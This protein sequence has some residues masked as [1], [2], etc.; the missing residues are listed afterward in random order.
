MRSTNQVVAPVQSWAELVFASRGEQL[1]SR[2]LD[3]VFERLSEQEAQRLTY[4]A[5]HGQYGTR[6]PG[7]RRSLF[8]GDEPVFRIH[9]EPGD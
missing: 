3:R 5:S 8:F 2:V 7:I 6:A 1:T 9:K 4:F